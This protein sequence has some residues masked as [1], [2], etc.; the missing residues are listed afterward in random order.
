M[1]E[2]EGNGG[3]GGEEVEDE[4]VKSVESEGRS[5]ESVV[6]REKVG[7]QREVSQVSMVST[8]SLVSACSMDRLSKSSAGSFS[9]VDQDG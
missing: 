2:G 8:H 1:F 9:D 4:L 6:M 5:S 7:M 3:V